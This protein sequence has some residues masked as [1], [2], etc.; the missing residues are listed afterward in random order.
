MQDNFLNIGQEHVEAKEK[1]KELQNE[2]TAL[3]EKITLL[4]AEIVTYK[5]PIY[6]T[7]AEDRGG[8]QVFDSGIRRSQR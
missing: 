4:E 5:N 6:K 8:S 2:K 7:L 3:E 1:I